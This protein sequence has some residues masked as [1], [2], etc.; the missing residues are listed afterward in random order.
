LSVFDVEY[1]FLD[2]VYESLRRLAGLKEGVLVAWA[3]CRDP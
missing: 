1:L 2:E 3:I